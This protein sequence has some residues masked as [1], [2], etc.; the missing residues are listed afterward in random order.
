MFGKEIKVSKLC[1]FN[2]A[3]VLDSEALSKGVLRYLS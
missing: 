1:F 3:H 2:K